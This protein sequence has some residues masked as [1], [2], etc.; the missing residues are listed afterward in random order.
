M[1]CNNP[2]CVCTEEFCVA[3][4]CEENECQCWPREEGETYEDNS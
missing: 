4:K 3:E 1:E 2:D